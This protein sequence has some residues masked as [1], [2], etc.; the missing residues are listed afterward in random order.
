MNWPR[1]SGSRSDRARRC[2]KMRFPVRHGAN[3]DIPHLW[4]EGGREVAL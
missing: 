4:V 2:C 3:G 1:P